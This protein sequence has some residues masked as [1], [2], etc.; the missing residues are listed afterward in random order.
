MYRGGAI[1]GRH[2]A[3]EQEALGPYVPSFTADWLRDYPG[4]RYR[5]VEGTLVFADISGFTRLTRLLGGAG[6][7]GAEEIAETINPLLEQ[8]LLTCHGYGGELLKYGG[9]SVLLLFDGPWHVERASSA[10]VEMRAVVEAEGWIAT[11]RGPVHMR[12]SAGVHSGLLEFLLVGGRHLEL[13]V[14]GDA[15]SEVMRMERTADA[16]E[17]VVSRPTARALSGAGFAPRRRTGEGFLLRSAPGAN[18]MPR[19]DADY[20]TL[21]LGITLSAPLREHLVTGAIEREQRR[22]TVG[23]VGFTGADELLA[24]EGPLD[25]TTV[26]ARIISAAQDA[27]A[28]NEVTILGTDICADGATLRLIAGAPRRLGNEEDRMLATIRSIVGIAGPLP[29]R[30]GVNSGHAFTGNY[31][32]SGRQTYSVLGDCADLASQLMEHAPAGEVLTTGPVIRRAT[33]SFVVTALRPFDVKGRREPVQAFSVGSSYE[34]RTAAEPTREPLL[35]RDVELEVLLEADT[36][37]AT[38]RGRVVEVIGPEGIGKSRLLAELRMRTRGSVLRADG[39]R[40]SATTPYAPFLRMLRDRLGVGDAPADGVIA[41]A[42][43]ARCRER[44]PH[45]LPWLPLM[46]I[47]GG[48]E[49][50]ATP[51]IEETDPAVRKQRLEQLVPEFLS[52]VLDGPHTFIFDDVDLMDGA[53]VDLIARLSGE[54]RR[55]PWLIVTTRRP[56]D[57][58]APALAGVTRIELA[59]LGAAAARA[60]LSQASLGPH[61]LERFASRAAGNPLFLRELA[62]QPAAG[63]DLPESV[64]DAIAARIER[65]A[66]DQR[67]LVRSAAVLGVRVDIAVLARLLEPDCDA[68]AARTALAL[69]DLG[70]L[71]EPIDPTHRRFRHELV[72]DVAYEGLPLPRR[73]E[74]HARAADAIERRA[75]R[76]LEHQ[77][78]LLWLHSFH[79][80][81]FEAAWTYAVIAAQSA[82][83]HYASTEAAGSCRRA[84]AAAGHL[85]GLPAGDIASV[86]EALSDLCVELGELRE[87]GQAL[88]RAHRQVRAHLAPAARVALKLARLREVEGRHQAALRWVERADAALHGVGGPGPREARRLVVESIGRRARIRFRQG[89]PADALQA[90]RVAAEQAMLAGEHRVLAEALEY[91]DLAAIE[92][93]LPAGKDALQAL[94]IYE[95]LGELSP[96]AKLRTTLGL[97]AYQHGRWADALAHYA[98]AE[99]AYAR[100]GWE[101]DAALSLANGAEILVDQRRFHDARSALERA[102]PVWLSTGAAPEIAF[103]EHMLGR[104]A[105]GAGRSGEAMGRFDA[106]RRHFRA[107]DELTEILSID[108]STA[109][110][111]LV[112]GG[113]DVAVTIA[114]DTLARAAA[115]GGTH[116]AAPL[117]HRVRGEGLLASGRRS[118]A[119]IALRASLQAA[120]LRGAGHEIAVTLASLVSAGAASYEDEESS[121]RDERDRL[122][123]QLGIQL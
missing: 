36:E 35:G 121:W 1:P 58:E 62:A 80:A 99:S 59:P 100:A 57:P 87:A 104:I 44:S 26:V 64:R 82:R 68:S 13:I 69:D 19:L 76:E 118:D 60:V 78:E 67:E 22:V 6:R 72:R 115:L 114:E 108:A 31:G 53:S 12:L 21:D 105:A 51:E 38:G 89:R 34:R 92:L 8:L 29:L 28:A 73:Q 5:A 120:R 96:Q 103:G 15:A 95:E 74:L 14:T 43:I 111:V 46:G 50:P 42:L 106:A 61:E 23:C 97:L 17:V 93:G 55:Q 47:A 56:R 107:T 66:P 41:A 11:S 52:T 45:L 117:L 37:A 3:S 24:K 116:A 40:Y 83:A 85:P 27:A 110:C 122:A 70:E 119:L 81:R 88:L 123:E 75:G 16:G 94:A 39:D 109:E 2:I 48:L 113:D 112:G 86:E 63:R 98:A 4:E 10:A 65:L 7:I 25:Y 90:A 33:G 20:S 102:M 71:L 9:N 18:R 77:A 30:G 79:G 101:R 49:L 91:G 84:L 54:A 32:P